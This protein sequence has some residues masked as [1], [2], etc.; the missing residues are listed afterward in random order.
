MIPDLF[1]SASIDDII[2][3]V[4]TTRFSSGSLT[5]ATF[6]NT[7]NITSK[8]IFCRVGPNDFNY[9]SNPTFTDATGRLRVISAGDNRN[10]RPFTFPTTIGLY[11]EQHQLLAVAKL[12]RPIEKN[13]MRDLTFRIRLDF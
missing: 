10:E 9:S 5:C 12:S 8:L 13:D 2:D 6:Q 3:H 7:T 11:N 4:A 1:V